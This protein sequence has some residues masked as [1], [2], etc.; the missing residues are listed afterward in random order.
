MTST[1]LSATDLRQLAD[2]ASTDA[3]DLGIELALATDIGASNDHLARID[4]D[5]TIAL[6]AETLAW[7]AVVDA[8]EREF[9]EYVDFQDSQHD[10]RCD[11]NDC[12][13]DRALD[14]DADAYFDID[15]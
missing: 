4:S 2:R 12:D 3:H 11:C 5:L 9:E 10:A 13:N 14:D 15:S 8:E 6:Q 7:E 1:R